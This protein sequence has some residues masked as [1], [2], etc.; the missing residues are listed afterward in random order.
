ESLIDKHFPDGRLRCIDKDGDGFGIGCG[1]GADCDESTPRIT[2]QCYSCSGN[3]TGCPCKAGQRIA[4]G[5]LTTTESG[6]PGCQ[7]GEKVCVEGRW[8]ACQIAEPGEV[9]SGAPL[10]TMGLGGITVCDNNPCDPYCQH[11]PDSPDPT[12]TNDAGIVGTD[13]GLVLVDISVDAGPPAE[14]V[15]ETAEAEPIPLDM[16]IMLDKSGSMSW[17]GRWDAVEDAINAFVSDP[18]SAGVSVALDYFH[19]GYCSLSRYTNPSVGWGLLPG[20]ASNIS[21][22]L[23]ANSPGGSTP[24]APALEGAID[25]AQ[26]RANSPAG[27]GHKVIVLLATDGEPTT[28]S[29]TNI[30]QVSD[31]ALDGTNG[32]PQ[33]QTFVIGVGNSTGNLDLIATKGGTG[34]AYM[35]DGGNTA[36]FLAAMEAIRNQSLGCEFT[37]PA[38]PSTGN[39]DPNATEVAYKLGDTGTPTALDQY[40]DQASCGSN[41]GFYYDNPSNPSTLHLCPTTCNLVKSN[42]NYIVD[43]TFLCKASCANY[44]AAIEPV[45]LD[46][47]VMLDQ[48]GSMGWSSRWDSVTDALQDFVNDPSS[49]GVSMALDYFPARTGNECSIDNYASNL[50]VPWSLLPGASGDIVTSLNNHYPSGGTPTEP[51]LAGAIQNA[52]ARAIAEPDHTVAVV[53][54]T[55][56]EPNNCSSDVNGVAAIAA[57]GF[58]GTGTVT[59]WTATTGSAAYDDIH[60]SGTPTWADSD[61]ETRG[62]FPIGFTF[63]YMGTNYSNFWVNTNGFLALAGAPPDSAYTNQQLPTGGAGAYIAPFWDDLVVEGNV[64]YQTLGSAPNRRLVVQW[65]D[66]RPYETGC[67]TD[68]PGGWGYCSS[69]CPCEAGRGDC[70]NDNEC[71]AG[72]YC[73]SNVGGDYGWDPGLDMCIPSSPTCSGYANG[74]WDNCSASCPCNEGEGDCDSDAECASGLVCAHDTGALFGFNSDVDVCRSPN[75]LGMDFQAVLFE[76]GNVE[77]RYKDLSNDGYS[78]SIGI[79]DQMGVQGYGFSHNASAVSPGM[80]IFFEQQTTTTPFP[81]IRTYVIGVGYETGLNTIAAAGG[82]G[83]AYIVSNGN[84]AEFLAAMQAIRNQNLECSYTIPPSSLGTVDPETL[85]IRY[86]AGS[87]NVVDFPRLDD[88][89]MCGSGNGFYYDDPANPTMVY[90]CPASCGMVQADPYAQLNIFYDCLGGYADGVFTRDYAA[91]GLCPPSFRTNWAH[92]SW[93]AETPANSRIDFTVAVADTLAG[94]ETAPEASLRFTNPPGPASL[95]GANVGAQAGTPDTQSGS[96]RVDTTLA[97]EG[98]NRNAPFLRVRAKL[99]ASTPNATQTPILESWNMEVSC[100]PSE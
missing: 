32:T 42:S 23:A 55:D 64:Y 17:G 72:T 76:D 75:T 25:F 60:N 36:Q 34:S 98:M 38:K 65:H 85:V 66:A 59:N 95:A 87:G 99:Y 88:A 79:A 91:E 10:K 21:N 26:T 54:A 39:I 58:N 45:P 94:L 1:N 89:S 82:S 93:D 44:E 97:I 51:A 24:T 41:H 28:C 14:C 30:N 78:A 9:V 40:A 47:A 16:Y 22:S 2:N 63:P 29:P 57:E 96:A 7:M 52:R 11:F 12:L 15:N 20:H 6:E 67:H 68:S 50:A 4:C 90:L 73:A 71:A 8:S 27:A 3:A 35:V 33:I 86:T 100:E 81:S 62:S 46:L 56:G 92:W 53:L 74:A 37:V 48:S 31:K 80:S 43:L 61:D 70:D 84:S 19:G 13:S 49:D 83:A 69:S 77:F 18:N 5:E